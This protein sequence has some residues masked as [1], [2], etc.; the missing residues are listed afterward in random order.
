MPNMNMQYMKYVCKMHIL[1]ELLSTQKFLGYGKKMEGRK[2]GRGL[3][4]REGGR[5]VKEG[6]N[7]GFVEENHSILSA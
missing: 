3:G 4:V 1:Y 7:L 5:R 6:G 2:R